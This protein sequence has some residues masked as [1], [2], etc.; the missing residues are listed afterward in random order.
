GVPVL[1][2]RGPI[3]ER[4]TFLEVEGGRH[5][6]QRQTELDHREGDLGLYPNDHRVGAAQ[7]N[8][9]GD[10]AQ[11]AR[12]EGVEDVH[13]RHVDD[14]ATGAHVA[15]ILNQCVAQL[16]EI[17]IGER[18]LNAGDEVRAVL[19][20]RDFQTELRSFHGFRPLHG[21]DFVPQQSFGLF[22]AALQVTDGVHLGEV[23][24]YVD[25][26]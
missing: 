5:V 18:R 4:Q 11:R 15:D 17:C 21:N 16:Q 24:P 26:G 3:Q 19:Q 12:G 22:D 6:L 7:A 25:Q 14:D 10:V 23:D 2:P 9:V 20:D 1:D 8:H 13:R